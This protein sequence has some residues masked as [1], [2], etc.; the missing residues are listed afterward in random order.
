MG[1]G[2]LGFAWDGRKGIPDRGNSIGYPGAEV[3]I[4]YPLCTLW[5]TQLAA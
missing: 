2:E 4:R 3:I 5:E 1:P